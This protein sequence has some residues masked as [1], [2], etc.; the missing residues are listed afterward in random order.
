R[1]QT[2]RF[3]RCSSWRDTANWNATMSRKRLEAGHG[4]S[5]DRQVIDDLCD[6]AP[7]SQGLVDLQW[8]DDCIA[9]L[10]GTTRL[11]LEPPPLRLSPHRSVRAHHVDT[12]GISPFAKAAALAN[13]VVALQIPL[14]HVRGRILHLA[15]DG[16]FGTPAGH[17]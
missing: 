7:T 15:D 1:A 8:H 9:W 17:N 12:L 4:R 6:L 10:D 16:H 5:R 13:V 14:E 3:A 2:S 11:T